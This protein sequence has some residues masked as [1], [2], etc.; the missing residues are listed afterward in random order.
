MSSFGLPIKKKTNKKNP[1]KQRNT[2]TGQGES[3]KDA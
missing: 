1:I 3:H 2:K